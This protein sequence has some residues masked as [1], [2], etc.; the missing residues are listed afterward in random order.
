MSS[1]NGDRWT[2]KVKAM[3]KKKANG[4][5]FDCGE[6]G[7]NYAVISLQDALGVF[8]CNTCAGLQ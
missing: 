3:C 7:A 8:V 4:L 6:S 5:C 2:D 1:S